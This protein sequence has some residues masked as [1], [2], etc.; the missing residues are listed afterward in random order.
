MARLAALIAAT[1]MLAAGAFSAHAEPMASV[2]ACQQRHHGPQTMD[3]SQP[4]NLGQLK[5]HVYFYIC[6]G[7][8]DADLNKVTAAARAYVEQRAAQ[9]AKPALVLDIDETSLSNLPLEMVDDFAFIQGIDCAPEMKRPCGFKSWVALAEAKAIDGTIALYQ[10][11]I[12]NHVAVFFITGRQEDERA[13]TEKNLK[14]AGYT[15]WEGLTLRPA[16]DN[17][18]TVDYKSAAREKIAEEGYT[19]IVNAGDQQSDLA[20]GYAERAYKLPNPMYFIP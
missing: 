19:I 18:S 14:A 7:G 1:V 4:L 3:M 10:A 17:R 9:V 12:Q 15:S 2:A 5:T 13:A 6:S 11:A 20:G 16:N 8:Y